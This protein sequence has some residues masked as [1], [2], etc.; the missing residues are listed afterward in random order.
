MRKSSKLLWIALVVV[1]T[2]VVMA[3]S[4]MAAESNAVVYGDMVTVG[5]D[6]TFD[7]GFKF[8]SNNQKVECGKI[9]LTWDSAKMTATNV[10]ASALEGATVETN[11]ETGKVTVAWIGSDIKDTDTEGDLFTVSFNRGTIAEGERAAINVSVDSFG[12]TD[13]VVAYDFSGSVTANNAY[14]SEGNDWIYDDSVTDAPEVFLQDAILAAEANDTTINVI[15]RKTMT[16]TKDTAIGTPGATHVGQ[17]NVYSEVAADADPTI[18]LYL[19][20]DVVLN[21]YGNVNFNNITLEKPTTTSFSSGGC[22]NFVEGLGTFGHDETSEGT[23]DFGAIKNVDDSSYNTRCHLSGN[24]T[25]YTGSYWTMSGNF[26]NTGA[27]NNNVK[28]TLAGDAVAQEIYVG[29]HNAKSNEITGTTTVQILDAASITNFICGGNRNTG[30][31]VSVPPANI[32]VDTTG[33]VQ[34]IYFGS[35][36]NAQSVDYNNNLISWTI[37]NATVPGSTYLHRSTAGTA[38]NINVLVDYQGGNIT[39]AAFFGATGTEGENSIGINGNATFNFNGGTFTNNVYFGSYFTWDQK[40][41]P[42]NDHYLYDETV[43][44]FNVNNGVSFNHVYA[45]YYHRAKAGQN[46]VFVGTTTINLN[47][48]SIGQRFY[49][50]GWISSEAAIAFKSGNKTGKFIINVNDGFTFN[51]TKESFYAGALFDKEGAEFN[52]EVELN[53]NGGTFPAAASGN[54]YYVYGGSNLQKANAIHSGATKVTIS[55]GTISANTMYLGSYI[56]AAGAVHSGNNTINVSGGTINCAWYG[57]SNI[58]AAANHSGIIDATITGMNAKST[59]YLSSHLRANG[60]THEGNTTLVLQGTSGKTITAANHI[61]AGSNITANGSVHIG[62]TKLYLKDIYTSTVSA[63]GITKNLAFSGGYIFA[64]S[65]M[66]YGEHE[67]DTEL[68]IQRSYYSG[69]RLFG[70]CRLDGK[71]TV[72]SGKSKLTVDANTSIVDGEETEGTG[73][74]YIKADL[75]GGSLLNG[76]INATDNTSYANQT[77]YSEVVLI[78]PANRGETLNSQLILETSA[79][80]AAKTTHI[81][82]G[83][84]FYSTSKIQNGQVG[85]SS[86]T[87]KN[88]IDYAGV[89]PDVYGGSWY[90]AANSYGFTTTPSSKVIVE[91]EYD[92]VVV[93]GYFSALQS[94]TKVYEQSSAVIINSGR[95]TNQV[96]ISNRANSATGVT[97]NHNGLALLEINVANVADNTTIDLQYQKGTVPNT[98]IKLI[99]VAKDGSDADSNYTIY[100]KNSVDIF[101]IVQY[102][103]PTSV[104]NLY[105]LSDEGEVVAGAKGYSNLV[106]RMTDKKNVYF[107]DANSTKTAYTEFTVNPTMKYADLLTQDGLKILTKYDP[108][109]TATKYDFINTYYQITKFDSLSTVPN[110]YKFYS[111]NEDG[112][113]GTEITDT[114]ISLDPMAKVIIRSGNRYSSPTLLNH[115][116]K[117]A[118]KSVSLA[119]S[120]IMNYM[121][122]KSLE[123]EY[124][125]TITKAE[126]TFAGQTDTI[127]YEKD[128]N[129]D[130]ILNKDRY[131][132][133]FRDIAPQGVADDMTIVVYA[134]YN[135]GEKD[136]EI[137]AQALKFG[138]IDYCYGALNNSAFSSYTNM[139]RAIVDLLNYASEAQIYANYNTE[140]LANAGLTDEQKALASADTVLEGVVD[141]KNVNYTTIDNPTATIVPSVTVHSSIIVRYRV[142]LPEGVTP[143]EATLK[144]VNASDANREWK[145]TGTDFVSTGKANEYYAYLSALNAEQVTDL[146]Y[147]TVYVGETAISNTCQYTIGSY[148]V[149]AQAQ[150]DSSFDTLKA[151][152][153]AMMKYGIAVGTY[154][155]NPTV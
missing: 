123:T 59:S 152:T 54:T 106:E 146:L 26:Y 154:A 105:T 58:T 52:A 68:I 57:G 79:T 113:I 110:A 36:V 51:T 148:Y 131:V 44:T 9:T 74:N 142:V 96:F 3:F 60:A 137:K 50:G 78:G 143:A 19:N 141:M 153:K 101:D 86:V 30:S 46:N 70:G 1:A 140:N 42:D 64:G 27:T 5:E 104:V 17:V 94:G 25:A 87:I 115:V 67:G 126:V 120:L 99:G 75:I 121:I 22:F 28:L 144:I 88:K 109:K 62:I 85:D 61:G 21:F 145:L 130:A 125:Y 35:Y 55:D 23:G 112:T 124:G 100:I 72:F 40:N 127:Y 116:F 147:A 16:F 135:D 134:T 155:A 102:D 34:Q 31:G 151:V 150:T 117:I 47:G 65:Q 114:N 11:I 139:Q 128:E 84:S 48:G 73:W 2:F 69:N 4:A 92:G 6:T 122:P 98:A 37:K 108:A 39:G 76:Y 103:G 149:A 33:K 77:G 82:V 136:V 13:S 132:F 138:V 71:N 20:N 107:V 95:L 118:N 7:V 43:K 14:V 111:V 81:V 41:K 45:G 18:G 91:G 66:T 24:V 93:G 29:K 80:S 97:F 119:S 90:N 56:S 49:G 89:A 83:G 15:L 53:I 32:T 10:N 12:Y 63:R 129:G 133:K 38:S 8:K